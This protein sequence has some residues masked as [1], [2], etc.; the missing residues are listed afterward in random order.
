MNVVFFSAADGETS[1]KVK[2]DVYCRL[3]VVVVVRVV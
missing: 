3:S 1:L 2:L